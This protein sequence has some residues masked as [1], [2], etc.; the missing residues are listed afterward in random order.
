[1]DSE[2]KVDIP[3]QMWRRFSAATQQMF[4]QLWDVTS[5]KVAPIEPPKSPTYLSLNPMFDKMTPTTR[6][7]IFTQIGWDLDSSEV[8]AP[9]SR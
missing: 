9:S 3:V 1:M 5:P 7:F 8:N 2:T 4:K 6:S